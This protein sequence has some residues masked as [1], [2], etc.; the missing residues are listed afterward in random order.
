MLGGVEASTL[1]LSQISR[2]LN[3]P[4]ALFED[5]ARFLGL[6]SFVSHQPTSD[7]GPNWLCEAAPTLLENL[8]GPKASD[9]GDRNKSQDPSGGQEE[10]YGAGC[11][12][13]VGGDAARI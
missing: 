11:A 2:F 6:E 4:M 7:F 3:L 10:R 1:A 12:H 8:G 9:R 13:R 5:P